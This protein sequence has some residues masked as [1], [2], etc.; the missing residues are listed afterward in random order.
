MA[1]GEVYRPP[2]EAGS[3]IIR[4][5]IGCSWNRCTFC[6]TFRDR[7]FR[8]RAMEEIKEEAEH[9]Y[10]YFK[11]AERIF[12]ADG[13]ALVIPTQKLIGIIRFLKSRYTKTQRIGIYG[14]P[15][16]ILRKPLQDLKELKN[17]GLGI[18]YLG[19][20]SGSDEV[21]KR[22]RKGATAKD[23]IE[24]AKKVKEAGIQLSAIVIAGLG[25]KE[26]TREHATGTGRTL[27]AM[28]PEFIG[29]LTL[30]LVEGTELADECQA[31]KFQ[32][33][34]ERGVLEE[35][36][37]M[38]DSIDATSCVFRANHAS[39]YLSIGGTLPQDKEKILSAIDRILADDRLLLRPEW[40]RGL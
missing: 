21:L 34:D 2:S 25:G 9:Y 6:G 33:L 8:L 27:S 28:D 26:L 30:M 17:E 13:N 10:P 5:T 32:A 19:L 31:G 39:N 23:M 3:L 35:L 37:M 12:L 4:V 15:K 11:D 16:D 40:M 38:V 18:I 24:C 20:E 29:V 36:K 7:K 1:E 22:V 14:G